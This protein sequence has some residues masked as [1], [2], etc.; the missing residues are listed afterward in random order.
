VL[1]DMVAFTWV[2]IKFIWLATAH[3]GWLVC[4]KLLIIKV[5]AF[6]LI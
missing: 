2:S 6:L 1:V 3:Y 5:V 4:P